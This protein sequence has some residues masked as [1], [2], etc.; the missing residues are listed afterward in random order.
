MNS[1]EVAI[2][3]LAIAS[4]EKLSP[5]DARYVA[6]LVAETP[7]EYRLTKFPPDPRGLYSPR[8]CSVHGCERGSS[9]TGLTVCRIH[10]EQ[11]LREEWTSL[12]E[13]LPNA[14]M[15][16]PVVDKGHGGNS[17]RGIINLEACTSTVLRVELAFVISRRGTGEFGAAFVVH[18]LN[19]FIQRL[20][21]VG[22]TS[23]RDLESE[24]KRLEVVGDTK[25]YLQPF[26]MYMR[27][28]ISWIRMAAGDTN[29][30][31]RLGRIRG[32][33]HRWSAGQLIETPWLRDMVS[34]WVTYR[35]NT[36][37]AS[38]QHIGAQE[39]HLVMFAEWAKKEG[40][41][42]PEDLT[43]ELLLAWIGRVNS[44]RSD[45]GRPHSAGWRSKRIAAVS[46]LIQFARIEVTN[47]IPGNAFYLPG[48]L[49]ERDRPK[50][51]FLEP[52]VIDTLR[53]EENLALVSDPS[54]RTA[55]LIMMQV[56]LRAGHTCGLPFDCLL[57]LNRGAE[58]DKWALSF[59]DTKSNDVLTVPVEPH[60]A[61]A[62][63][64]QQSRAVEV[65][66][67]MGM[68]RPEYLF[69]NPLAHVTKRLA[70]E[71]LSVIITNW[72]EELDVREHTGELVV[73][74][75]HRFRHTFATE[76]LAK[77]VP[78][79]IVQKLLGH[80]SIASTEIYAHVTDTHMRAEWEKAKFINVKGELLDL[81]TG[82]A[83]EAEYLLYQM[84]R[85]VQPLP[86]GA[87]GL[88]IQK[89]CPHANACLDNCP[90]FLTTAEFLPIHEA[91][92]AA[93]DR[94]ISAAEKAGH[95][96][97][98]EINRRPNDNLKRII[99]TIRGQEVRDATEP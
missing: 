21:S 88:P 28:F 46:A 69:P 74:T 3:V 80:R 95:L 56:G 2:P 29:V 60:V 4:G 45:D 81:P 9:S 77:G 31:R 64:E 66:A 12:A 7:A 86:N 50:P 85:A 83:A 27:E 61:M 59:L 23:L 78:M 39:R 42:E 75:A 10:R 20:E 36:R 93:F 55:I 51:R 25:S 32:G 84:G 57:D 18:T 96:R 30:K 6:W 99:A 5:E 98:V 24:E 82:E 54:H 76:M 19:A 73:V 14:D 97:I 62:I 70:P 41:L 13:F 48:E 33:S 11:F 37:A 67:S 90:H 26:G 89:S 68:A 43:R 1:R 22:V 52:R 71:R 34:R 72:V 94:T 35:L 16:K 92:S 49:P 17:A 47:R 58:T 53:R 63:R 40:M 79:E 44:M 38:P 91:Q 15:A 65:S 8:P 87:C